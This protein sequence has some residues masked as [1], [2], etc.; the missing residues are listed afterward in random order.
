VRPYGNP[1][2]ALVLRWVYEPAK[3][4]EVLFAAPGDNN[5]YQQEISGSPSGLPV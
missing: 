1:K 2:A 4:G 5:A 3:N